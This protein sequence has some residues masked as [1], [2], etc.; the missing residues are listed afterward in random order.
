VQFHDQIGQGATIHLM[1]RM[2]EN[3]VNSVR[4]E[5]SHEHVVC[6]LGVSMSPARTRVCMTVAATPGE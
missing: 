2:G 6:R 3:G 1:E 4:V 5:L